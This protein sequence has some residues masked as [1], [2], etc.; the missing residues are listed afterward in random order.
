[1]HPSGRDDR[2]ARGDEFVMLLEDIRDLE[3]AKM[4]AER[5]QGAF[6]V[7]FRVDGSEVFSTAGM[8]VWDATEGKL[9]TMNDRESGSMISTL[10]VEDDLL[11]QKVGKAILVHCG[12]SVDVAGNGRKAVEAFARQSGT[13]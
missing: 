7:P 13:T 4:V 8:G 10:L 9:G 3:S 12:C 11:I 6:A 2:P 1:M 5:V